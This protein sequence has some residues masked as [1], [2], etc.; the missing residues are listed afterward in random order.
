MLKRTILAAFLVS[1]AVVI[2]FGFYPVRKA[3]Q[4]DPIEA[5]RYE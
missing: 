1:A 2:F 3:A 5:L 4:L